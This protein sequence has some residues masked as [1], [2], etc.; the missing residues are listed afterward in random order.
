MT[1]SS[2]SIPAK[3]IVTAFA[4]TMVAA[5]IFAWFIVRNVRR[6]AEVADRAARGAA[7]AI[8][9]HADHQ[10]GFPTDRASLE[11]SFGVLPGSTPSIDAQRWGS[12]APPPADSAAAWPATAQ[13]AGLPDSASL[14]EALRTALRLLSIRFSA[15][16]SEPPRLGGNGQPTKLGT[17]DEVNG[18][19]ASWAAQKRAALSR[20]HAGP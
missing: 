4:L 7:W 18:W 5:A 10:G 19:M 12:I 17:L 11:Q 1:A 8:L 20:P 9:V 3:A 13:E 15:D 6:D 2:P 14:P 16:P